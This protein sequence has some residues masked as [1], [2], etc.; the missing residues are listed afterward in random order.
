MKF[1]LSVFSKSAMAMLTSLLAQVLQSA[2][3]QT[4]PQLQGDAGLAL[5]NTPHITRTA[6]KSNTVLPYIYADYGNLYARVNTFGY[7]AMPLGNGHLELAARVSV[8][9]YRAADRGIGNRSTPIPVGLGTLQETPYGAFFLYGFHD[10]VSGGTLLDLMYAAEMSAGPIE[11]YPQFGLERRS[12]RYMQ[13]LYAVSSTEAA[14]SGLSSYTPGKASSPYLS[15]ALEY[16]LPDKLKLSFQITK[17][18]L[19]KSMTDS[20]LINTSTQTSGLLALVHVFP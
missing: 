7:Q 11:V 12:A 5:Y 6:D 1:H 4:E 17:K 10:T 9:A 8:E 14:Q 2:W 13:H 20:P 16:P 3:A 19:G 18:W 15:M